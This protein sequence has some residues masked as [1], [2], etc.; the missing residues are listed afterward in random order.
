LVKYFAQA[1]IKS[2][3]ERVIFGRHVPRVLEAKQIGF[4]AGLVV[5]GLNQ[6]Q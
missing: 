5:T 1:P 4:R 3:L 6:K 2:T